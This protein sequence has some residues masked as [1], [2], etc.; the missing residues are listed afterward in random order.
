MGGPLT[1]GQNAF[2]RPDLRT[3]GPAVTFSAYVPPGLHVNGR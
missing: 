2:S 1:L 3:E